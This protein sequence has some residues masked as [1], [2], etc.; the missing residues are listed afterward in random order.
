MTRRGLA[1]GCGGTLGFAWSAAALGAVER[2]MDWDAREAVAIVG[3]SAG[4]EMGAMLG[5]GISVREINDALA[6]RATDARLREHLAFH[7]GM[8]PPVPLPRWPGLGMTARVVTGAAAPL[9]AAA[10]LLP[11][12]RG[13][14]SWLRALGAELSN[15]TGWVDHPA[16]WI[17]TADVRTG[18]RVTLGTPGAPAAPLGD[19]IAASWA[20]P[21]WFP[22]VRIGDRDLID[23]G[24]C[25]TAS[26]DLLLDAD[27]DEVVIIAP[28]TSH[29]G[30]PGRGLS[31]LE[32]LLRHAMTQRLDREVDMLGRAGVGVIRVEPTVGELDAMGP[33]FMDLR[34]REA[35]LAAARAAVPATVAAA[36]A[37]RHRRST[38]VSAQEIS[39]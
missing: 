7:P 14:A 19:A 13:D 11:Q 30:A 17:G 27:V 33:N 28:M 18:E 20:I 39:A 9:V 1:L 4:A 29:G 23:G 35:T 5:A 12:G 36:L 24:T 8:V 6:G 25:S 21:G 22:P 2:A 34:R 10:G 38:R 32:R 26:A 16:L 15:D 3:A 37:E 31:R